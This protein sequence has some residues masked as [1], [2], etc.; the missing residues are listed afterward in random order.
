[1]LWIAG[2]LLAAAITIFGAIW[3]VDAYLASYDPSDPLAEQ[4]GLV[5]EQNT[6]QAQ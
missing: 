6:K 2:I 3:A 1:M 5:P 4:G